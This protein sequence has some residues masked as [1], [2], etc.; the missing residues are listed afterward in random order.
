MCSRVRFPHKNSIS[1]HSRKYWTKLVTQ[2]RHW[3]RCDMHSSIF[4]TAVTCTAESLTTL[5]YAQRCHWHRCD[6]HW[7]RCETNFVDFLHEFEA[8]FKKAL[9]H[10]SGAYKSCLMKKKTRGQKCR[11]RVPL[12]ILNNVKRKAAKQSQNSSIKIFIPTHPGTDGNLYP[13]ITLF[14]CIL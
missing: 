1:N 7:H 10:V 2:R 6:M 4:D 9:T 5:W 8:I 13:G 12:N 11:V 14:R 3:H